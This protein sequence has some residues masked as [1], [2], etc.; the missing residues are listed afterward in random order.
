MLL[1]SSFYDASFRRRKEEALGKLLGRNQL[2]GESTIL[3]GDK[4]PTKIFTNA[5]ETRFQR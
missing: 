2:G 5:R 4:G 1:I 3:H